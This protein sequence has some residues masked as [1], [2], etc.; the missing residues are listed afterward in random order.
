MNIIG[1]L[2]IITFVGKEV[3]K[4]FKTEVKMELEKSR[5]MAAMTTTVTTPIQMGT[6]EVMTQS[7]QERKAVAQTTSRTPSVVEPDTAPEE[8]IDI[9][10]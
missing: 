3:Q 2:P 5:S 10:A 7:E 6:P 8:E 9:E 1:R 4:E